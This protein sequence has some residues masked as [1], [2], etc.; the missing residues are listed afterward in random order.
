MITPFDI[1]CFAVITNVVTFVVA[2]LLDEMEK[3]YPSKKK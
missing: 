1:A 3:E 2:V